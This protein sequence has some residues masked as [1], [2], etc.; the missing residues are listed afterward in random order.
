MSTAATT[1]REGAFTVF[2]WGMIAMMVVLF[3]GAAFIG[4]LVVIS[5]VPA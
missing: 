1:V 4:V 2:I 3:A 5:A